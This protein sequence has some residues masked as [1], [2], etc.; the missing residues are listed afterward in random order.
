MSN[1]INTKAALILDINNPPP[2]QTCDAGQ[3]YKNDTIYYNDGYQVAEC[4]PNDKLG[5]YIN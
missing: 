3:K 1:P 2:R 5:G 4:Q